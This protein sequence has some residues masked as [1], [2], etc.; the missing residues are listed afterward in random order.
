M[1]KSPPSQRDYLR[2]PFEFGC[3]TAVF[4]ADELAALTESGALLEALAGGQVKPATADQK[5]FL[6]VD[7]GEAEPKTV[8]ERAW[9]RL[10][11]RR[12]Y[13]RG[14]TTGESP[15]EDYGMVEFDHDRCWW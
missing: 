6:K 11:A 2:R 8:L 1:S 3:S 13:E 15:A 14:Q 12:E 7:R 4:P 9:E 5:H 10:K